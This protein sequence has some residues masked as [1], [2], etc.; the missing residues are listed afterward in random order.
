MRNPYTAEYLNLGT[1]NPGS[2]GNAISELQPASDARQY[3][4]DATVN[5]QD[6]TS[7]QTPTNLEIGSGS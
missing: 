7:H 2:H 6:Q 5:R 1:P 3:P 4:R